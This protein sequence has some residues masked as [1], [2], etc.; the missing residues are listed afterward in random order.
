M[1]TPGDGLAEK[2]SES[3]SES[4]RVE[5]V[6]H[7]VEPDE[8]FWTISRLYY[9]SGRYYRAL[10]KANSAKI[11]KIDRL[12]VGDVI[13][14]PPVEELD[15]TYIDSSRARPA[16]A[17]MGRGAHDEVAER[18]GPPSASSP[19]PESLATKR[20]TRKS[21]SRPSAKVAVPSVARSTTWADVIR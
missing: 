18:A 13:L 8:N 7:V 10:W 3:E 5:V 12:H 2:K 14:I 20:T 9:S 19:R 4:P 15:P 17:A 1:P 11:Q 6:P 21:V 16:R